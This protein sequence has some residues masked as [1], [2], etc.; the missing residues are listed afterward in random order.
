MSIYSHPFHKVIIPSIFPLFLKSFSY[1]QLIPLY[2]IMLYIFSFGF[3]V[4]TSGKEP[5]CQRRRHKKRCVWSLGWENALEEGMTTHSSILAWRI[6]C[7]EEPV[8]L[9][10]IGLHRVGHDRSNLGCTH[11]LLINKREN[12]QPSLET[13]CYSCCIFLPKLSLNE[14]CTLTDYNAFFPLSFLF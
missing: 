12:W 6:P 14:L 4:G 7:I 8:G 5:T 10:S 11:S 13:S 1:L 9:E 2:M 3:P